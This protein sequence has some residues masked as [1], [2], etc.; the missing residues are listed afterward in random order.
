MNEGS[1]ATGSAVARLP[2][3]AQARL[4][5]LKEGLERTLGEELSCL[6]VYGSAAR[7]G[8]RD[9]QSDVDLMVVLE[10]ASRQSLDAIPN[11]LQIARYAARIEAM[12]LTAAEIPR[13]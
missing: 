10:E 2:A 9:G 3:P 1:I 11:A 12:I 6:L 13:A 8:Y 5:E 4:V 7:G